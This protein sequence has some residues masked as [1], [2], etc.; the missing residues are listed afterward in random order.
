MNDYNLLQL[1]FYKIAFHVTYSVS[2]KIGIFDD[3]LD[4]CCYVKPI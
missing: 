1:D 2:Y 4:C 3:S